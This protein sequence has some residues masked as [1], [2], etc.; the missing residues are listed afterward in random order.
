MLGVCP[1]ARWMPKTPRR[2]EPVDD[3]EGIDHDGSESRLRTPQFDLE[4]F[5]RAADESEVRRKLDGDEEAGLLR[6][7][8]GAHADEDYR[9]ALD[10]ATFVLSLNPRQAI[11]A[12]CANE[13]RAALEEE[14][15][16]RLRGVPRVLHVAE[17]APIDHR[18]GFVLSRIDGM[19]SI[20]DLVD[21]C[22]MTRLELLMVLDRLVAAGTVL[23]EPA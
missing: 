6:K 14:L 20:D 10:L 22:G 5:A 13:C 18:A 8:L 16:S 19:T 11:A 1:H 12:A 2:L 15:S 7:M 4:P 9:A 17:D 23:I 3:G 21:L